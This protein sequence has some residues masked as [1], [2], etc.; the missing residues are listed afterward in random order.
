MNRPMGRQELALEPDFQLGPLQIRPSA[1]RIVH[2][3][4]EIRLEAL[5][6]S[7]LVVLAQAAGNTVTR[8]ELVN[9]CWQGRFVS[10]EAVARTISKVRLVNRGVNPAPFVLEVVPKV[11]YRLIP[12]GGD[13][14]TTRDALEPVK[15]QRWRRW[16][17]ATLVAS[18]I[19]SAL[20]LGIA[21]SRWHSAS[22]A[23]PTALAQINAADV[24]D[25]IL[26]LNE[27]RISLYLRSGWNVNWPLSTRGGTALTFLPTVCERD[28]GNNQKQV[29]KIAKLL[30]AA[31]GVPAYK[32]KWGNNA[33][34]VAAADRMCGPDHLVTGY[35]R[36]ITPG[37]ND[38]GATP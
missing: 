35:F 30:V 27:D 19:L 8:E 9:T 18:S 4:N 1:C 13:P 32:N 28:P 26:T 16:I 29:L 25:A 2:G 11:G 34:V 7:V 14:E 36:S 37:A 5:T 20:L 38:P 10:D 12:G 6:M 15:H 21:F 3:E 33:Y 23:Q 24:A 22:T 17:P 31:G